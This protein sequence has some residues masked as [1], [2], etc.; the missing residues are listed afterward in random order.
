MARNLQLALSLLAKDGASKVL[1][2]A[3]Q[4]ILKQTKTTQKASDEQAKSQQ[5]NTSSA[6]RASRSLQDEY[7]RASSA[8]STLGIRAERE[9]QREIQQ[10]M[11]AY[12]RL[13]RSGS[14]SARE[15]S[16]AFRG[17]SERVRELRTELSGVS[18]TMTRLRRLK[19]IVS[20]VGAVAG[21]V[22]AAT[23]VL[24]DPVQRQM[25]F[26][27]RNA[28]IANTAYNELSSSERIKKI[29]VI[30]NAIRN[31]VRYGGGT[32]E[33]AQDT[34]NALFAGGLDEKTAM[35]ILP[36]I[37]RYA[38]ASGANPQDL[39][40]I[41]IGAIKNFGIDMRDLPAV[42]DKAIR[43]GEN[44][45]Y[46]LADMAGSLPL[47]LTKA[48]SVGM[49]GLKDLD[50]ILAMLQANA[51]TAGDNSAASTNV[52]NLLDKYTSS[53][54]QNAL[55]NKRFR[56][57]DGRTLAYTDYMA[58]QRLNGVS[59]ADAFTNAVSG[60]VSADS[61]VKKLRIEAQKYKGTDREKDILAALDLVISSITSK[62]VAD[63]QASTGLKTSIMKKDFINDQIEGTKNAVG[64]GAASFDVMS[65]TNAYK[66]QQFESEKMFAEQ[67]S[68]KPVA[69]LYADLASKLTDYAKEYPEL[70]TAISGATTGIKAMT[71]AAIAF[72]GINFLTSGGIK[73][74]GGG[75]GS[76]G[77]LGRTWEAIKGNGGSVG[78]RL[79]GKILAPVALYQ[80]A[81]DAPLV[82]V[83]RG[84]ADARTRLKADNY[85]SSEARMLDAVKARPGLMDAVDEIKSWWSSPATIGQ[86]NPATTCVP[87]Y[88]LPQQQK[89]P[90]LVITTKVML[91]DREIAQAVNNVNGEQANRG[92]TGGPQ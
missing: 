58:D 9:I 91:D 81:Q 82:H 71:A 44:G 20:T 22:T 73:L 43:S 87:A 29:P 69:D 67:D 15:Q 18:N 3:M 33:S 86:A 14:L 5:Q 70:T 54:T 28:E 80:G 64:A 40:K 26:E 60:I 83:E 24:K 19:P 45:K 55:K 10:T 38:S 6:I 41:G 48:N 66:S 85:S 74:P 56:T 53:D 31:A 35:K 90:P 25:A 50:V 63:T 79:L 52:N 46:E 92:S 88:L 61:R 7:R 59:A 51:E 21:G 30:N 13:T 78:G 89:Q 84:D 75:G 76:G 1:R 34:L 27:S 62:I 32:P 37:T 42:Y 72:A 11:A 77:V 47:T 68:M 23:M 8:R 49:S 12:N 17:M 36:D 57:K 65:S 4:D 39:A 2:Q 16:R